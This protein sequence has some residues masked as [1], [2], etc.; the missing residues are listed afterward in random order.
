[1]E[2]SFGGD[3]KH[4]RTEEEKALFAALEAQGP[5]IEAAMEEEDFATAMA[6]LA[7]LRTPID[8]FFEGVQINTDNQILRRN[9]LNL[10]SEIRTLCLGVADLTRIEG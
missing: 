1:M 10:L 5:V 2:Y 3:A 7:L 6:T 9:R 8:A 4:A